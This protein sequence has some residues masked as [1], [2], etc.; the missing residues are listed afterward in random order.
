[1]SDDVILEKDILAAKSAVVKIRRKVLAAA[2]LVPVLA[3]LVA[4][5]LAYYLKLQNVTAAALVAAI[6]VVL[7]VPVYLHW[8]RHYRGVL[9]QLDVLGQRVRN[10]EV[11]HASQVAF[12]SY[13]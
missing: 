4:G 9:Q 8:R 12:H 5:C 13:R 7:G 2:L 6:F 1:M 11:L 3:G 10:G